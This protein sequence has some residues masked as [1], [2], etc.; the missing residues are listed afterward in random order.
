MDRRK[1]VQESGTSIE[2]LMDSGT[3]LE[4]RVRISQ[5]YR[6][7]RGAQAPPNPEALYELTMDRAKLYRSRPPEGLRVPLPVQQ[8]DIK[9]G[10]PMEA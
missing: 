5:W 7:V 1:I 4:A 10:I 2:S 9:D 6:Q 3:V 8:S